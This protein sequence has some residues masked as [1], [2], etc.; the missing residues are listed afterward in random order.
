MLF[1][2]LTQTKNTFG[3]ESPLL[4]QRGDECGVNYAGVVQFGPQVW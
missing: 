2:Q 1:L 4:I 3:A